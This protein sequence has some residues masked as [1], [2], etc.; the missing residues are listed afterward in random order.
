[1]TVS[2]ISSVSSTTS[3]IAG[4][5]GGA[6]GGGNFIF[7]VTGT[8]SF[9]SGSTMWCAGR[10][11]A[12]RAFSALL[13]FMGGSEEVEKNWRRKDDR[14]RA[15]AGRPLGKSWSRLFFNFRRNFGQLSRV[16]SHKDH[17]LIIIVWNIS[18]HR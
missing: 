14:M 3:I 1:M 2:S 10:I 15:G 13:A 11:N 8:S 5:T 7:S 17:I 4:A 12:R 16:N 18:L 6:T 9:K